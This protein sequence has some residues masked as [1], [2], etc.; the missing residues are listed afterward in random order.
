MGCLSK[1]TEDMKSGDKKGDVEKTDIA[2]E[3]VR[4]GEVV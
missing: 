2:K 4:K 1:V 3:N